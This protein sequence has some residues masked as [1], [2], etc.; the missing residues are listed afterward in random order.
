MIDV[1]EVPDVSLDDEVVLLGEQGGERITAREL[2]DRAGLIEYEIT[3]GI[4][5]RVPR[6]YTQ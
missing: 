5:K 3:C 6:V 1:T 4:S 2:A